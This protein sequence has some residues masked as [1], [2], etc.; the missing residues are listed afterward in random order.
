MHFGNSRTDEKIA[1]DAIEQK[2][3]ICLHC[4][5]LDKKYDDSGFSV[6]P[7]LRCGVTT[8]AETCKVRVKCIACGGGYVKPQNSPTVS[9]YRSCPRYMRHY[10]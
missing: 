2:G 10:S 1:K 5:L 4:P 9:G 7:P 8:T 3:K 6:L